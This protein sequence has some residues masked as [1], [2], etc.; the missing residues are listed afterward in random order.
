M[1]SSPDAPE[2]AELPW[3]TRTPISKWIFSAQAFS[4]HSQC[5]YSRQ[6][7]KHAKGEEIS[8]DSCCLVPTSVRNRESTNLNASLA[9]LRRVVS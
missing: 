2:R 8:L 3:K 6:G 7:A 9:A 5:L 4:G 1:S